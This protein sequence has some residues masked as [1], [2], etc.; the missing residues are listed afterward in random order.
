M[1]QATQSK[2]PANS[3]GDMAGAM[4]EILKKFL[5]SEIDDMIPAKIVAYD[6]DLNRATIQPQLAVVTTTGETVR[7]N[8]LASVPVV[9]I[10]GGGFIL[11][12]PLT[13]GDRG[14]LKA[15][16]RDISNFLKNYNEAAPN[17]RRLHDFSDGIFIP[18]VMTGYSIDAEDADNAVLQTLDGSVRI[19]LF[20]D[21][22][23]VTSPLVEVDSP[24]ITSTGDAT[25][26][27][28]VTLGSGATQGIARLGD[29]VRVGSG[30][31]AGDWPI[32]TAS[33]D[34]KAT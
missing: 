32:V 9:N 14:W 2:N 6:R 24:L 3:G 1:T 30:S 4:R 17:T 27:G 7:R 18:D 20:P 16:D 21:K 26:D 23:K 22:V 8:Q 29:M 11:S 19:S 5:Q 10:G 31:S 25:I 13:Q 12:F 34:H 28:K 33:S 15:S